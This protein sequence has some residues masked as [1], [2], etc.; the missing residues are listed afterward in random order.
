MK[1]VLVEVPPIQTHEA[2]GG[3]EGGIT[4]PAELT[5][6]LALGGGMVDRETQRSSAWARR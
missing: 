1:D 3:T 6:T 4:Q 2:E 5:A